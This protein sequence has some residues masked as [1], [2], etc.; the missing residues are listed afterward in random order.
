[1]SLRK[2]LAGF[3]TALVLMVTSVFAFSSPAQAAYADCA[4]YPGTVCLY[5]FTNYGNPIW[6]Q[7]PSQINGCRFL[8]NDG[9]NDVTTLAWNNTPSSYTLRM[10]INYPCGGSGNQY[11]D[12]PSGYL[13][14][15][16]SSW[17]NQI[18]AVQIIAF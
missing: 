4:N 12:L 3:V 14:D 15:F 8:G 13:V 2:T 10:W 11:Y 6:R 5:A 16:S 17:N 18:S 7:F 1:M 9:W